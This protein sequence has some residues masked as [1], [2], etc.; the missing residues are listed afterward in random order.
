MNR[1]P[2]TYTPCIGLYSDRGL[3]SLARGLTDLQPLPFT[4]LELRQEAA[5]RAQKMSIQGVQPKLSARLNNKEQRFVLV[6]KQGQYI[7]KPQISDYI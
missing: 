7:L 3:K 4:A 6:D 1:C 2:L 5:A